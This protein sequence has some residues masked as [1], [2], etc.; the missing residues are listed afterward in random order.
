[1]QIARSNPAELCG[2][3]TGRCVC[4]TNS[5]NYYPSHRVRAKCAKQKNTHPLNRLWNT[6]TALLA[7]LAMF[8]ASS[9]AV[10]AILAPSSISSG[11]TLAKSGGAS[12]LDWCALDDVG[13]IHMR[14]LTLRSITYFCFKCSMT[15]LTIASWF[16][17]EVV[18]DVPKAGPESV[19][20][21]GGAASAGAARMARARTAEERIISR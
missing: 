9:R 7:M 6:L 2:R 17:T 3:T 16:V 15:L 13:E 21:V 8:L 20:R 18:G 5:A 11:S 14:L 1:M 19:L 10:V 12:S 4:D